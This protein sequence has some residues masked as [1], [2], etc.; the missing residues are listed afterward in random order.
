M[1]RVVSG[2]IWRPQVINIFF[3]EVNEKHVGTIKEYKILNL[4][5]DMRRP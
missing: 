2:K 5:E 3:Y 1:K 4:V